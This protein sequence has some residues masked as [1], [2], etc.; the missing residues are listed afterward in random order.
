MEKI[1]ITKEQLNKLLSM[2]NPL[3]V[4]NKYIIEGDKIICEET[5]ETYLVIEVKYP[6]SSGIDF[7]KFDYIK[8]KV[9][10]INLYDWEKNKEQ[11]Y[12]D[13]ILFSVLLKLEKII[14]SKNINLNLLESKEK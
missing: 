9:D 13:N 3:I 2:N 11:C 10:Y 12:P 6:G 8:I 5:N 7:E 14:Q 1:K 4:Y